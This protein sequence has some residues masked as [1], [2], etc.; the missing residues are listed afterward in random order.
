VKR[1]LIPII[2]LALRFT[3]VQAS[4]QPPKRPPQPPVEAAEP[5][6]EDESAKPIV[7]TL[8]PLQAENEL[9]IGNFYAKKGSHKAAAK[10]FEEAT[11]WNPSL[12][13]AFL[14]LAETREK[15]SDWKSAQAAYKKYLEI[16]PSGGKADTVRKKLTQQRGKK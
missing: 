1:T 2:L 5:E 12:G 14:R 6:E 15:L 8:N 10:R 9:R 3:E 4:A 7:Y 13:E 11:R 16:E